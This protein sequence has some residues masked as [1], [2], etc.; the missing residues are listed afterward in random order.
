METQQSSVPTKNRL[1]L[2]AFSWESV[3][4]EPQTDDYSL[5]HNK[6]ELSETIV[7]ANNR[8]RD[9]PKNPTD[10]VRTVIQENP[11]VD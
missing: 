2:L 4:K 3:R 8:D 5:V 9:T 6:N 10:G 11:T 1:L 7:F